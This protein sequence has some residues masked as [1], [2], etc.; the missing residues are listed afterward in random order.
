V[1]PSPQP[2]RPWRCGRS[3]L[4]GTSWRTMT[5]R[6]VRACVRCSGSAQAHGRPQHLLP[7]RHCR[8]GVPLPM[9]CYATPS[10]PRTQR[11]N[12]EKT[13]TTTTTSARRDCGGRWACPRYSPPRGGC[14]ARRR[15]RPTR[16]RPHPRPCPTPSMMPLWPPHSLLLLLLRLLRLWPNRRPRT[17]AP[18]GAG[19]GNADGGVESEADGVAVAA[20]GLVQAHTERER[21]TYMHHV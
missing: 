7:R 19:A 2:R 12:R 8:P 1:P 4:C 15:T 5:T 14:R 6:T 20:C 11:R 17:G 21:E 10:R 16:T 18:S 9:A 13:M 3:C